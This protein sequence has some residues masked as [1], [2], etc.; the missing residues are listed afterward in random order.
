M[1]DDVQAM[2]SSIGIRSYFTTNREHDVVFDNGTYTCKE[3]YD[4]NITSDRDAF[5]AQI[6]FLHD[7][8]MDKLKAALSVRKNKRKATYNIISVDPLGEHEVFD[9][10]VDNEAHTYWTGG[11]NVSNCAEVA[12]HPSIDGE[13]GWAFCNLTSVNLAACGDQVDFLEAAY[14][15]GA[16]GTIQ[17]SYMDVGYLGGPESP[18]GRIMRRDAL[19]GVSLTGMAD[20][21]DLAFDADLLRAG[22]DMVRMANHN[23]AEALGIPTAARLTTVKPEGTGSLVVR[24]GNGIHPHHARRYLR[25]AEGGK[26]TDPLVRFLQSR[27]PEA[28]VP[29][30][31]A[32]DEVKIVFPID[33]GDGDLWLKADTNAVEHLTLVKKVQE[34]WVAPGTNRGDLTHNVSNTVLVRETEWDHVAETIWRGRKTYAG[35]SLLGLSGD[36]DYAQAPFVA[37]LT[38]DEIAAQYGTDPDRREKALAATE[39]WGRLRAAWVDV[40]WTECREDEDETAGMEVVACAGGAC[41]V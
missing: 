32:A 5:A 38:P 20:R 39:T 24:A 23:F 33:L 2:L 28:V 9:I 25:Y 35:V 14:E 40:D 37:V 34:A 16:L 36:L 30:A 3:S 6:G 29:S 10:T 21:R 19:L 7:Y 11:L 1:R 26:V 12:L 27:I 17:A 18:S 4:I 22:A 41:L 15:A 13:T 31:Y 8:K